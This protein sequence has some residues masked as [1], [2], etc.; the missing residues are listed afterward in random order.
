MPS[1]LLTAM[2]T[3]TSD[4]AREKR[5]PGEAGIWIVILGDLL[6]FALLFVLFVDGR[7]TDPELFDRSS[8]RLNQTYGVINTVLLLTS[9]LLVVTGTR[10]IRTHVKEVARRCF[11]AATGCGLLFLVIKALEYQHEI[12]AGY[13]V[14]TNDFFMYFYVLTAVHAFHVMVGV[15]ALIFV[16]R[17]ARNAE[18]PSPNSMKLIESTACFWHMVDLLWI[19]IFALLYLVK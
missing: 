10:A 1:E 19:A 5:V 15:V 16:A 3:T 2:E 13:R 11:I 4:T 9:S 7:S 14:G 17:A 12:S 18:G 6:V 8:A